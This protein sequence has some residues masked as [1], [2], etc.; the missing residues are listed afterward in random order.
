MAAPSETPSESTTNFFN[1]L[2]NKLQKGIE[3]SQE[4]IQ[5][6]FTKENFNVSVYFGAPKKI[7]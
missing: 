4:G 1:D 3:A 7:L 5:N 2:G 6:T